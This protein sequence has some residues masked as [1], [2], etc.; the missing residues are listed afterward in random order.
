MPEAP[1]EQGRPGGP[2]AA[3]AVNA[4]DH[5]AAAPHARPFVASLAGARY[6]MFA[7]RVMVHNDFDIN[8]TPPFRRSCPANPVFAVP[9]RVVYITL[10][11]A[12]CGDCAGTV[13]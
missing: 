12:S 10:P 2:V 3:V 13:L 7:A 4:R 8:S 5:C 6:V 9:R 1:A 11:D